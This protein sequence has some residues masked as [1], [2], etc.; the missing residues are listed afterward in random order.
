MLPANDG[1]L[2]L[3]V[4][5][6]TLP[7]VMLVSHEF[8]AAGVELA[9][10]TVHVASFGSTET[11]TAVQTVLPRTES[12]QFPLKSTYLPSVLMLACPLTNVPEIVDVS[13]SIT[14]SLATSNV[15]LPALSVAVHLVPAPVLHV[16][17]ATAGEA[18]AVSAAMA[19]IA[20]KPSLINCF[21]RLRCLSAARKVLRQLELSRRRIDA[22]SV[23]LDSQP[24][25]GAYRPYLQ[26]TRGQP[27]RM[28]LA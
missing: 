18:A 14:A 8:V 19:K 16:K 17:L 7:I 27:M 28:S 23:S 21:I 10:V 11:A 25:S 13:H 5:I 2:Q 15:V 1:S 12:E 20:A 22:A 9:R 6:V 3:A 26:S 4:T 24:M